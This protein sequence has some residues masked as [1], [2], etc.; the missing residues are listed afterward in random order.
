MSSELLLANDIKG[1]IFT[2]R[3]VQVMIDRDLADLYGVE[4][5]SLNQAVKRNIDRFP[6]DFMFQLTKAEWND[7]IMSQNV[8]VGHYNLKSQNVISSTHG[9]IRKMPF[10]FTEQGVAGLSGVLK[11]A[12]AVKVHVEIMRAFVSMRKFLIE[13]ASIFQ[14]LDR[15]ELKQLDNDRNFEVL[16]DA[17]DSKKLAPTQGIFFDGQIFD[18]Y[19][20]VSDLIRSAKQSITLIDNYIDE[21]TIL[22]LS[23]KEKD[24]KVVILIKSISNQQKLDIDK[25][26]QQYGNFEI[27]PFSKSHD[28]FLIIDGSEIYHIGASL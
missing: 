27:K 3:G 28:R 25:A 19:K 16:F 11:S 20:F 18:A 2:I 4:T 23:K 21:T 13:N 7:F 9:G 10:A 15:I 5:R 26:N 22:I 17:L 1:K 14:R 8:M 24:V 6:N 12:S